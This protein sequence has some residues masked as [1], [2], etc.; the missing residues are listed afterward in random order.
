MKHLETLEGAEFRLR[1]F[2]IDLLD[3]DSLMATINGTVSIFHLASPY[4]VDKVKDPKRELLD[5]VI[6]RTINVLKAA[7]ECEVR[8]VVVTS[9]IFAII[10]SRYW[11]ADVVKGENCWTDVDY[12]KHTGVSF[13]ITFLVVSS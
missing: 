3:Y 8:W 2:Q 7:K 4:I 10:P 13:L 1:L 11:P 5:P 12:C 6:K 9:S